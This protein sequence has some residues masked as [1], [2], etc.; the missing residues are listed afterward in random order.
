MKLDCE[1]TGYNEKVKN[2][3]AFGSM[4]PGEVN[5]IPWRSCVW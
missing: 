4:T 5:Q 2:E 3:A 1:K